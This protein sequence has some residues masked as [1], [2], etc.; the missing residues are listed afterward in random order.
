MIVR[1]LSAGGVLISNNDVFVMRKL[2]GE[3]VMPKGHVESGE[4]PEQAAVR[5]V[6]EETGLEA[7]IL[8]RVGQTKYRFRLAS[9]EPRSKTVHWYLMAAESRAYSLEPTFEEAAFL[10]M[11]DAIQRLTFENDR[12]ILR[13]AARRLQQ[14]TP[15]P[16]PSHRRKS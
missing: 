15:R 2:N 7:R 11:E 12:E 8:A 1:E 16:T 10:P 14:Q 3:W 4:T 9:G 13:Q 6:R 5:E